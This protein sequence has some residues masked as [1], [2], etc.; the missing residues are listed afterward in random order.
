VI[1]QIHACF[2]DAEKPST[3]PVKQL[4]AAQAKLTLLQQRLADQQ[5]RLQDLIDDLKTPPLEMPN[6]GPVPEEV[7]SGMGADAWERGHQ[8]LW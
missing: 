2:A 5:L 8:G 4:V 3:S 1:G 7:D 6:P